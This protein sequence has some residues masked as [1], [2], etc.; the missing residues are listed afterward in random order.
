MKR[1][2]I[3]IVLV[4]KSREPFTIEFS[5][6]E[7]VL[8]AVFLLT[9]IGAAVFSMVNFRKLKTQHTELRSSVQMLQENLSKR[10]GHISELKSKLEA[11]KELILLIG[12]NSDTSEVAPGEYSKDIQIE[13]L[14]TET[15]GDSLYLRFQLVN[16]SQEE[17]LYSGYVLIVV[18]HSSG[19]LSKFSTFPEFE[20]APGRPLTYR[21]GDTYAIRK[22]KTIDVGIGLS[23]KPSNY[24]K[25]KFLVFDN[26]GEVLLYNYRTYSF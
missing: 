10:E 7:L 8:I 25:I 3:T 17:K 2:T 12:A 11:Q 9:L 5:I 15:S 24:N 13:N 22:F 21:L 23:D 4:S 1:D 18:E 16:K 6:K 20:M 26:E 14:E 19:D